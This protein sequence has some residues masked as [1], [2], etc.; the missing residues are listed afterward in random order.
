MREMRVKIAN[1][2]KNYHPF[3]KP[4]YSN[5]YVN[6]QFIIKIPSWFDQIQP[7]SGSCLLSTLDTKVHILY[8][9]FKIL[10]ITAVITCNH[11]IIHTY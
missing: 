2:T 1:C 11:L 8:Y 5:I 3:K 6:L 7:S 9:S 10:E 4:K